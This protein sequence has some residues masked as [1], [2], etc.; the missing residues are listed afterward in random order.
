MKI[1]LKRD[2]VLLD[3]KEEEQERI[4]RTGWLMITFLFFSMVI[5]FA[6]KAIIGLA[7]VQIMNELKLNPA[8]WGIVG[9]SFFWLF[10]ITGVVG[11]FLAD[12][13]GTKK[14]LALISS[15]WAFVQFGTLFMFNLPYLIVTRII[16]GAGEGPAYTVTMAAGAKWIPQKRL[17]IGFAAINLG[18]TVGVALVMPFLAYLMATYGWRY[19][20]IAT[21]TMGIAW[22]TLWLLFGKEGPNAVE[23]P[24]S[25]DSIAKTTSTW[26][27]IS[28]IVRSKEF[29]LLALVGFSMHWIFAVLLVW[30]PNYLENVRN[31][32]GANVAYFWAAQAVA[33]II[34]GLLSDYIYQK[35]KSIWKSRVLIMG[36]IAVACGTLF[37]FGPIVSSN[38]M[39]MIMFACGVG[40]GCV[41]SVF[42]P[43]ILDSFVPSKHRAKLLGILMFFVTL[44]GVIGPLLTGVIIQNASSQTEGFTNSFHLLAA[45]LIVFGTTFILFSRP[46]KRIKKLSTE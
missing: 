25:S 13:V 43:A 45:L 34:F 17:G 24:V 44:A 3:V 23:K 37:Y 28:P 16:L 42:L 21:G 26:S 18:A 38:A 32:N 7:S 15:I 19:G 9:S 14:I 11:G 10:S 12:K 27:E 22:L 33:L 29:V 8:Q 1:V 46:D 40:M 35:T 30:L 41:F 5:N 6:D 31:I 2:D 4:T 36:M 20:F 39:S